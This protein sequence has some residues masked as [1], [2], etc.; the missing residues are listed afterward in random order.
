MS[1]SQEYVVTLVAGKGE[2]LSEEI[3]RQMAQKFSA[4][5]CVWL[6][7]NEAVDLFFVALPTRDMDKFLKHQLGNLPIDGIVQAA[8]TRRKKL[9]LADMESTIIKQEILDELADAI[10]ARDNVADITRRAMNGELDFADALRARVALIKAQPVS[11]LDHVAKNIRFTPGAQ[12]LIATMRAN[13]ATCW[14][15]SG[16]FTHFVEPVAR[17]LGFDA[18]FGNELVVHK[19]IITGE[20]AAPILDKNA[21]S[22]L[23]KKAQSALGVPLAE[24]MTVGDGANDVPMLCSTNEGGGLGLAYHARPNVRK[25]IS[26]QIN[27]ADLT[28]LL[29]AQGYRRNDFKM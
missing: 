15:V 9:L 21:K 19:D 7:K 28:A 1:Q 18:F 25:I 4:T 5:R 22:A 17:Q 13:G 12:T 14:L 29:Y 27:H 23:L 2:N 16:G 3:V 11:I 8:H 26:P 24:I 20:V 10:G 6:A